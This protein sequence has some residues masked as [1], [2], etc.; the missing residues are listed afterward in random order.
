MYD[1][2]S[3]KM[4]NIVDFTQILNQIPYFQSLKIF[5]APVRRSPSPGARPGG[6]E[7]GL[8]QWFSTFCSLR[9]T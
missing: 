3:F 4:L 7:I 9:N 8:D 6:L 2:F 1:F 5:K